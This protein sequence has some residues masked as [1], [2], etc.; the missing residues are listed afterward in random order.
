MENNMRKRKKLRVKVA[1]A[2][3]YRGQIGS[4]ITMDREEAEGT[5]GSGEQ[6]VKVR[7]RAIGAPYEPRKSPKG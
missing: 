3:L 2:I 1:W 5:C 4:Y 6:V 7:V